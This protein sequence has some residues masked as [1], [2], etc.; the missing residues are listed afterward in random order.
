M[1]FAACLV[2]LMPGVALT[3]FTVCDAYHDFVG[4]A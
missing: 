2:E 1:E 3:S 4:Q